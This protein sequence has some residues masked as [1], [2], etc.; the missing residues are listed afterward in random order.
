[1]R[2]DLEL[3]C[4]QGVRDCKGVGPLAKGRPSVVRLGN[5]VHADCVAS[6]ASVADGECVECCT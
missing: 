3:I 2:V 4:W 6:V 5:E 1:M